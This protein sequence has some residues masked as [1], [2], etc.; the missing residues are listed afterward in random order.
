MPRKTIASQT[1]KQELMYV[2]F[3]KNKA[4]ASALN[5]GFGYN[6]DQKVAKG[7]Y[8]N[9]S[10]LNID[11]NTNI[12]PGFG[13]EDY[14]YYRPEESIP[15][16][17][18]DLGNKCNL[19]YKRNGL[20]RN[21]IDLM[22]DFAC[23]G[24]KIYHPNPQIQKFYQAW[25]KRI[26]GKHVTERFLNLLYRLGNV[27]VKRQKAKLPK[28]MVNEFKSHA[29]KKVNKVELPGDDVV[30]NEIPYSYSFINPMVVEVVNEELC[31]FVGEYVYTIKLDFNLL[32][33]I[34]N[35]TPYTA[36]LVELIPEDIKEGIR[37]GT[38]DSI[39]LDPDTIMVYHYKKDDWETWADPIIASV[40]KDIILLEK[41]KLA[42]MAALDGAISNV[43]IWK[44][45]NIE[46]QIVPTP[47]ATA[48]LSN[49]L[50]NHVG[51]GTIDL[52]WGPDIELLESKSNIYQFLGEAKY[53]ATLNSIYA[54]MGIPPTLTGSATGGGFTNNFISL[55]TLIE[56]LQYGRDLVLDFWN[57]EILLVQKAMGFRKPAQIHFDRMTLSD[58]AA[59]KALVIQLLDRDVISSESTLERFGEFPELERHRLNKEYRQRANDTL[60]QKAGSFHN[61]QVND[62]LRKIALQTGIATPSEVHLDMDPRKPGEQSMVD[63]DEKMMKDE[64]KNQME[65]LN[66]QQEMS[67]QESDNQFAH[68]DKDMQVM[69]KQ[70][71]LNDSKH[72]LERIKIEKMKHTPKGPPGQGRPVGKKDTTKR[73]KKV[74]KPKTKADETTS[75]NDG[76]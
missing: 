20:I 36:H 11:G 50:T 35:P 23:Q 28:S 7:Y 51:G 21:I 67:Q 5:D 63:R 64:H 73:K 30:K 9:Q 29:E 65:Q 48:R 71:Q 19:V 31:N 62:D 16:N 61:P 39:V 43:R 13:R 24:I 38:V 76:V 75:E 37:N 54:A 59:E 32:S 56:R 66:K 60:P 53:T 70:M 14:E 33:A 25:F 55:K 10:F 40:L 18:R 49:M 12:R 1:P 44:L 46:A 27:I 58:E 6:I 57:H 68:K 15:K 74:V 26:N 4:L 17:F 41:T 22:G 52:I 3:G 47:A 45:G 8:N 72:K 69:D 42:D 34:R 2:G